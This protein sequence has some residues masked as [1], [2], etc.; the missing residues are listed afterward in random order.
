MIFPAHI[1]IEADLGRDAPACDACLMLRCPAERPSKI[2]QQK[3][4]L[5]ASS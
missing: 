5:K 4:V 1:D 2:V 3:T